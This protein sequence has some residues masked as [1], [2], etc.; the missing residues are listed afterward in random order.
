MEKCVRCARNEDE[1]RL[2][3]GFYVNDSVKICERCSLISNIPIIKRP[4][5]DQL[6]ISEKPYGVRER[7]E[8]MNHLNQDKKTNK[9]PFE[10]LNE[11]EKKPELEKPEDLVFKL[12]DNFHWTIQTERRRKG[13]S[14][15]QMA[16]ILGES[17]AAIKMLEKGIVPNKAMNLITAIEQ[18]LKIKLIKK[19]SFT[20]ENKK[21]ESL[22]I[23]KI[24]EKEGEEMVREAILEEKNPKLIQAEKV[25][26]YPV[27]AKDFKKKEEDSARGIVKRNE[28][29]EN[30]FSKVP[31][32]ARP[33]D[34]AL[35]LSKETYSSSK[36]S[37]KQAVPTIYELMK[38]KQERDFKLTGK[39]IDLL[40]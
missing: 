35:S 3:D 29:I 18:Y 9:T 20:L 10:E 14:T 17:E 32:W 4:S 36:T 27:S 38:R 19:D 25:G 33:K 12:V 8:K 40:D 39:D 23:K 1:V 15:K 31:S 34:G 13:L 6:K 5:V 24:Q 37:S 30:D 22:F 11:L 2:F 7:L 26:G 21:D 16:D 28:I